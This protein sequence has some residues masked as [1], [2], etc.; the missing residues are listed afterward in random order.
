M[1]NYINQT[2]GHSSALPKDPQF[3]FRPALYLFPDNVG[4]SEA[5]IIVGRTSCGA[6]N[7][8]VNIASPEFLSSQLLARDLCKA[9]RSWTALSSK[10][11]HSIIPD[12]ADDFEGRQSFE[13]SSPWDDLKALRRVHLNKVPDSE[14]KV[15][16]EVLFKELHMDKKMFSR[17]SQ[18]IEDYKGGVLD[19]EEA[20][21]KKTFR[22]IAA[23]LMGKRKKGKPLGDGSVTRRRQF[24]RAHTNALKTLG[25]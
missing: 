3:R 2:V 19:A 9:V 10:N 18:I 5:D 14:F 16:M 12:S 22:E 25:R 4:V 24:A 11:I 8:V 7:I 21:K 20:R 15:T 13:W 23:W 1:I 17:A 6:W